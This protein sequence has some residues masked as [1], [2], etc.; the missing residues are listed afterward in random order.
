MAPSLKAVAETD[1]VATGGSPVTKG[2]TSCSSHNAAVINSVSSSDNSNE[3]MLTNEKNDNGLPEL[4]NQKLAPVP[5]AAATTTTSG[6]VVAAKKCSIV[7]EDP[8]KVPPDEMA[9]IHQPHF[10]PSNIFHRSL[11]NLDLSMRCTLCSE[12]FHCPVTLVPCLH[13]F[14]SLCIRQFLKSTYTG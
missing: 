10:Q 11:S 9:F 1:S 12:F 4:P 14:C 3:A 8:S 5:P 6:A 2:E 7:H 13:N